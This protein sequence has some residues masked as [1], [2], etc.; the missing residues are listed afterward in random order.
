M[1]GCL[2]PGITRSA[3]QPEPRQQLSLSVGIILLN[4]LMR[5]CG[6]AVGGDSL[7]RA[8]PRASDIAR[9]HPHD[10][11]QLGFSSNKT[12]A[13]LK[14]AHE[15]EAGLDLETLAELDDGE[16]IERLLGLRG[17]G[18]WTAEYVLLRGALTLDFCTSICSCDSL[19]GP[20]RSRSVRE[21]ARSRSF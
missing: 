6:L 8:F 12:R 2:E 1:L 9:M 18:R 5:R 15:V 4:R 10:L 16:A 13:L 21:R 19:A 3:D 11:R 14:L 17:I 20:V 7:L